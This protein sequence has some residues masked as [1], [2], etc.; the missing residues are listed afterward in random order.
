M[1]NANNDRTQLYS[2]NDAVLDNALKTLEITRQDNVKKNVSKSKFVAIVLACVFAVAACLTIIFFD[3]NH[4]DNSCVVVKTNDGKFML[5]GK[6]FIS[7]DFS[8]KEIKPSYENSTVA[9]TDT[10]DT[11]YTFNIN[12]FRRSSD[13]KKIAEKIDGDFFIFKENQIIYTT[14]STLYSHNFKNSVKVSD[15]VSQVFHV[16]NSDFIYYLTSDNKLVKSN[17]DSSEK[18][19]EN[20]EKLEYHREKDR[21]KIIFKSSDGVFVCDESGAVAFMSKTSDEWF[22][23]E[24]GEV[25]DNIYFSEK[26]DA[27]KQLDIVFEDKLYQSDLNMKKPVSSDYK[28]SIVFGLI[29]YIDPEEYKSAYV[30]YTKKLSRDSI[31]NY[32]NEL[33]KGVDC[34][35][36][37]CF[38]KNGIINVYNTALKDELLAFAPHGEPKVL[39]KNYSE[40]RLTLDVSDLAGKIGQIKSQEDFNTLIFEKFVKKNPGSVII[41]SENSEKSFKLNSDSGFDKIIFSQNGDFLMLEKDGK[42]ALK[43]FGENNLDT[44]FENEEITEYV[45]VKSKL[46]YTDKNGE[47]FC[48]DPSKSAKESVA[49]NTKNFEV[50]LDDYLMYRVNIDDTVSTAAVIKISDLSVLV[51]NCSDFMMISE[52]NYC[53]INNSNLCIFSYGKSYSCPGVSQIV[54]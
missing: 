25:W 41:K 43:K 26:T 24:P 39:L 53:Y 15:D 3:F 16:E 18:I 48:V 31:R 27:K 47:L 30:E 21:M 54:K 13:V 23:G 50:M 2:Q 38:G 51:E 10:Q 11:L 1:K 44:V 42:F 33:K 40:N 9:F 4:T 46:F 35:A 36:V 6:E 29:Q 52:D 49:K 12:K 32:I 20:I 7:I 28:K 45:F 8:V 5:A 19:G 34:F 22:A 17:L 14:G 37:Y